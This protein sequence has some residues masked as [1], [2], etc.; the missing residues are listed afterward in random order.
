MVARRK[1][2]ETLLLCAPRTRCL[3]RV[4]AEANMLSLPEPANYWLPQVK[5]Y[6]ENTLDLPPRYPEEVECVAQPSRCCSMFSL[7]LNSS[8]PSCIARSRCCRLVAALAQDLSLALCL[9]RD[10]CGDDNAASQ[11][12]SEPADHFLPVNSDALRYRRAARANIR[13]PMFVAF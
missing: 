9:G 8:R 3:V 1:S 2:G 4:L 5:V 11:P 13:R 6:V 12:T 10:S 7:F